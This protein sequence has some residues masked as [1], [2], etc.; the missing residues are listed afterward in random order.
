MEAGATATATTEAAQAANSGG[1][2]VLST[3]ATTAAAKT[4]G[5]NRGVEVKIVGAVAANTQSGAGQPRDAASAAGT[6]EGMEA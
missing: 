5:C 3:S 4:T 1:F 6:G 2:D